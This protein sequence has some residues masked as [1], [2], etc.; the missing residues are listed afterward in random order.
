MS[1]TVTPKKHTALIPDHLSTPQKSL[2][3]AIRVSNPF[4]LLSCLCL[5]QKHFPQLL[6]TQSLWG[7]PIPALQ[8]PI[9]APPTPSRHSAD[10]SL[11][12]SWVHTFLVQPSGALPWVLSR[13]RLSCSPPLQATAQ[14]VTELLLADEWS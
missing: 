4:D 5:Y 2:P 3:K 13:P 8:F 12:A 10:G 6:C 11:G 1:V 14:S 9:A 7:A